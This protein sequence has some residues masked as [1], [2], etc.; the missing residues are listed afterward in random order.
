MCRHLEEEIKN[1]LPNTDFNKT[2][3]VLIGCTFSDGTRRCGVHAYFYNGV[4]GS[5][6]GQCYADKL[7]N[8]PKNADV[9]IT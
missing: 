5:D 4:R 2:P 9:R 1:K 6:E 3:T 7:V 8:Y